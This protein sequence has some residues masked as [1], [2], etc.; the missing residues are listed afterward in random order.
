MRVPIFAL[1]VVLM[2]AM[3]PSGVSAQPPASPPDWTISLAGR[4]WV[5][6]GWS[7]WNFTSAGVDPASDLRWRGVD[8]V[9]G[10]VAADVVWKRFVW[11]LS[12]GGTKLDEGVL[13]DEEFAKSDRQGRFSLTRSPVDE[14]HVF[15]VSND[16]GARVA[17][18]PTALFGGSAP[19]AAGGYV[20][21]FVGYQYWREEYVAFGVQGSLFLP[22]LTVNQ[23]EPSSTR[24]LT[25]QYTRHSVRVGARTQVPLVGGLSLKALAAFSPWTHID[26]DA[27]QR[28]QT[29][30]KPPT[31]SRA[32]GG[33]GA[34][35]EAG[36]ACAVWGG[37]SAEAGFR[38]WRF[39]SGSGEVTTTSTTGAVSR[40]KLNEAITE[41]YGP[42]V[43]ASWRF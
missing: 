1:S 2:L 28:L 40:D 33:F 25:H 9:I 34:Q 20:D 24:V 43:G 5:T 18:W 21:A 31:R 4:V 42:Y 38:Y 14:G 37:L 39:D 35:V 30:I 6:S 13:I 10:E 8:G 19:P 17:R 36:L 15:Y 7:N 26:H 12:V 23:A 27:E 11:M 16:V 32:N 41:R 3:A 29:D 22:G